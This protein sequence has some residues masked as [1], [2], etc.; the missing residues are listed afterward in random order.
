MKISGI[1][2]IQ[3]KLKPERIY[4][5]SAVNI[6][7]RQETHLS[8]LKLNKHHNRK[9]QNHYNK[10]GEIDLQFSVLCECDIEKLIIMEQKYINSY[11][12]FFNIN[13]IAKSRLGA[14]CSDQTCKKLGERMKGKKYHLGIK[15]SDETKRKMSEAWKK[16]K[17]WSDETKE[18]FR[19]HMIGN[20]NTLG[21]HLSEETKKKIGLKSKGN[22]YRLG[23]KATNETKRKMSKSGTNAWIKRKIAS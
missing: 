20:K 7:H 13:P 1:Y 19:Q 10:Y 4:I 8:D 16:R 15:H 11:K 21:T 2:Q 3:S 12:P 9:L 6:N 14:K 22:K 23:Q 17:P 18:K 5:G